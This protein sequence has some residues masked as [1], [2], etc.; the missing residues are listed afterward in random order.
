MAKRKYTKK[1][2]YWKK[3][4]QSQPL[5]NI[6]ISNSAQW[7]PELSGEGFY[8]SIASEYSRGGKVDTQTR[9]NRAALGTKASKYENIHKGLLP[10]HFSAEG[11]HIREAIELCQKA[12]CNISIFRN[13]IDIMSEFANAE[14]ML[15]GGSEVARN[16]I[17]K[18]FDK[19]NLWFLKDQFFREYYRSGNVFLYTLEGKIDLNDLRRSYRTEILGLK[20]KIPLRYIIL[21]PY[22]IVRRHSSS[23]SDSLYEK[24]LSEYEIERLKSPKNDLD[25]QIFESL[26]PE[27]KKKVKDNAYLRD[28]VKVPLDPKYLRYCFYKKQDYEPF[29]IPFGFSVLDDINF[30]LEL[31][32][33][34][35]AIT[36]TIENVILL[37]TM[38]AEPDKGGVNPTNMVA[39]Q[40]LFQNESVGRV[41]VSD[42]T[43]KAQFVIPEI[44][45]VLGAEKYEIVNQD[46]KE[47]LQN[48]IVGQEK[49]S[50]TA[51]KAEIFLERLKESRNAFL[52]Q[53]LQ[54][55]INQICKNLGMKSIPQA[56]FEEVNVKDETQLQRV[57]TRLME[58]GI[59]TP[60]QGVDVMKTG[61][62][63]ES[64][65][66]SPAQEKF[67]E[68][69]E[70]GYYNPLVGGVPMI[71]GETSTQT[72]KS[73]GRPT[74]T[75]GIPKEAAAKETYGRT[76][77]QNVVYATEQFTE[78]AKKILKTHKKIKRL[79]KGHQKLISELCS[80]IVVSSEQENWNK[81]FESVVK[82]SEK[83][84]DLNTLEGVDKICLEHQIEEYPA[85][86]LYHSKKNKSK[87]SV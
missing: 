50:N 65:E 77:I 32:K 71:E 82:D 40:K 28:G 35:Q 81:N 87:K 74:G 14:I 45:K 39:M 66:I 68:E 69:R 15:E 54:P 18:W 25:K 33:I 59:L 9:K 64:K 16:F 37:I 78:E 30:K 43:T 79:N 72:P 27:A 6:M 73:A 60:Q 83:I 31:K 61:V 75:S 58:I 3:F 20:G 4:D 17:Q 84:M 42:Y 80:K 23:F 53:F 52:K 57:T 41:L 51:V 7:S 12:Y 48:I 2:E 85:A 13:A 62:F 44:N 76:D 5:G 86:L 63:P 10:Y 38:G 46:I 36:R 8:Q 56:K 47:G 70:M 1:S 67:V 22:D 34:D 11:I 49:F 19:I 26:S 24:I 55:E 21:N 29:A